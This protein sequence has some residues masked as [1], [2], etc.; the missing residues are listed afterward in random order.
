LT[1]LSDITARA[2]Q[3]GLVPLGALHPGDDHPPGIGTLVLLGPDEPDFWEI[4]CGSPEYRDAAADPV[5]RWSERVVGGL[6]DEFGAAAFFPFGGPPWRPFT[7]WARASGASWES[8]V[9][10]LVHAARGLLVSFRGAL[11]FTERLALP[12]RG[13]RPCDACPRPCLIA[14]PA[15]ALGAAGYDVARCH[16]FLDTE[17][18]LDCLARGC[19]VRRACPVGKG[20]R[21]DAQSAFYMAAFHGRQARCDD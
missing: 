9:R 10:L 19:A 13:Q 1:A 3:A 8:P 5:D 7:A 2:G 14:C 16:A 20:L 11:G 4:F 17:A 6:A 15:G 18:G 21:P 12:A